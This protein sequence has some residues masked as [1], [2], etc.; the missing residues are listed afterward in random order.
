MVDCEVADG[1]VVKIQ[2]DSWEV[3]ISA[4]ADELLKLRDIRSADWDSR[5]AI[6]AGRTTGRPVSWCSDGENATLLI[7]HDDET[8]DI[9]VT[10]PLAVVD[11]LATHAGRTFQVRNCRSRAPRIC[12]R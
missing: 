2:A 3:N 5:A 4:S 9:A 12:V 11:E 10:V 6:S 8:W 1:C 7:G